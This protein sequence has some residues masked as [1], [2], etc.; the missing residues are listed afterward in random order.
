[1]TITNGYTDL[2]TF[3]AR[4]GIADPFD[5]AILE[6]VIQA[7]SRQIDV[8]CRQRF[9]TTAEDETRYYT[10]RS[11]DYLDPDEP[12]LSVTSLATD[13]DG[14]RLYANTW[15]ASDYDLETLQVAQ[16]PFTPYI[17]IYPSPNSSQRFPRYRRGVK[18]VGKFGFSATTPDVVREACLIQSIRL[19]RR[20][21]APFGVVGAAEMG[22]AMMLNA[23]LDPD[24]K[25]LLPWPYRRR[26][27]GI[28]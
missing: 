3:K 25:A 6:A 17:A 20:K 2:V 19:F 27:F 4:S 24:V 5:D 9:Y 7:V 10:A 18:V 21:D 16:C 28:V 26:G 12:I 13:D 23:G 14:S 15:D 1:M 8:E 11:V 22:Q